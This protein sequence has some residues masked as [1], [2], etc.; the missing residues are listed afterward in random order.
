M[1]HVHFLTNIQGILN[2]M[3]FFFVIITAR[4]ACPYERINNQNVVKTKIANYNKEYE[5]NINTI[6]CPNILRNGV[7]FVKGT[8]ELFELHIGPCRYSAT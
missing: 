7:E 4:I 5:M 1:F 3:N 8:S 2:F 6:H